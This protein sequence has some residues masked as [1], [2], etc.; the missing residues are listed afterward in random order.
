VLKSLLWLRR[1]NFNFGVDRLAYWDIKEVM[2]ELTTVLGCDHAICWSF[3]YNF[4]FARVRW[5]DNSAESAKRIRLK[6]PRGKINSWG[7]P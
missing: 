5:P 7:A 6:M 4:W 3:V 1:E 2:A